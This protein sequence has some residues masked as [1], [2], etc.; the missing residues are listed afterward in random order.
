MVTLKAGLA[1]LALVAFV[2]TSAMADLSEG[3]IFRVTFDE[4]AGDT[5]TDQVSGLTGAISGASWATGWD[6]SGLSFDGVDDYVDFGEESSALNAENMT[7][8]A[9]LMRDQ[10]AAGMGQMVLTKAY[11]PGDQR[12]FFFWVTAIRAD[13]EAT[14]QGAA[15]LIVSAEGAW[16][17]NQNEFAQ[18]TSASVVPV[19]EWVHIA[20]TYDGSEVKVYINGELDGTMAYDKGMHQGEAKIQIGRYQD[21]TY[22][23][24]GGL[25]DDVMLW[26]R[27]LSANE[28]MELVIGGITAVEPGDKLFSTWGKLKY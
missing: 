22:S 18:A 27:A 8:A 6:S 25:M 21:S 14:V 3:L 26:N 28:I 11:D 7:A 12:S 16:G 17:S 19:G 13:L 10:E 5:V 9:W 23:M 1:L 24:Y 4:G 20:G 15:A 2:G